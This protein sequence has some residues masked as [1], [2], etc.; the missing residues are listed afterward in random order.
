MSKKLTI[1]VT[2]K[3]YDYF[4]RIANAV[5]RKLDDLV[6]LIFIEGIIFKWG[7]DSYSFKKED[8]EYT[9]EEQDQIVKNSKIEKKLEQEE[10]RVWN[11]TSEERKELGYVGGE[12]YY[13]GGGGYHDENNFNYVLAEQLRKPL[14]DQE[15]N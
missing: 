6:R 9:P 5:D 11:L 10:K 12:D 13:H 7:E 4:K 15:E 3:Q 1:E 8:D 14:I 2:D